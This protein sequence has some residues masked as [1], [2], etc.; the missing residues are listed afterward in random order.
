VKT[1]RQVQRDGAPELI[2]AVDEG[3]IAVSAAAEIAA[4]PH[5]VQAEVAAMDKAEVQ[6][7]VRD[8]RAGKVP[9][10][11]QNT[12]NNEWYAP[13]PYIAAARPWLRPRQPTR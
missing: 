3:R 6:D 12:G 8:L 13:A 4:Q 1:A 7:V 11:A 10:V 2:V 5:D 9:F